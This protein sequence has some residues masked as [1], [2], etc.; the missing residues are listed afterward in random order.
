MRCLVLAL[1]AGLVW[2]V[3]G[4]AQDL[5]GTYRYDGPNGAASLTLR[6][7]TP[8]RVTGTMQM[9][10]GSTF[11]IDGQVENGRAIGDITFDGD[12]GFFAAGFQG[13]TLLVV[14]AE[15]DPGTGQPRMDAGWSLEFTRVAGGGGAAPEAAASGGGLGPGA[16]AMLGQGPAQAPVATVVPHPTPPAPA[17]APPPQ[18]RPDDFAQTDQSPAAQA[19]MQKL[20]GKRITHMSSYS[21]RSTMGDDG[22]ISGGGYSDRFDAYLCSDGRFLYRTKSR[23]TV[24]AGAFGYGASQGD[25]TGRWRI[26]TQGNQAAIEYRTSDGQQDYVM[27]GFQ[28]GKTFWDGKRVFVTNE[29]DVCS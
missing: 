24:D 9:A 13:T 28:D 4:C 19:W 25:L 7:E 3:T 17:A 6:Q 10:N 21:S 5:S 27:L 1:L 29:N 2:P 15:R 18:A 26:V 16:S 11:V 12:R 14:V 20:R 23:T 8:S 22:N